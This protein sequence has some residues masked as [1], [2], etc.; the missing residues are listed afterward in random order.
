MQQCGNP[1]RMCLI[2]MIIILKG[3]AWI[4]KGGLCYVA[5]VGAVVSN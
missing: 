2:L 4:A 1:P 3:S 5:R